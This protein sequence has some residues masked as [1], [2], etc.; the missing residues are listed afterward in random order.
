[1]GKRATMATTATMR[2][3][4]L[5]VVIAVTIPKLWCSRWSS[6]MVR[7]CM[8]LYIYTHTKTKD[9]YIW[10]HIDAVYCLHYW[11][12]GAASI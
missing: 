1:V 5:R 4:I 2:I 3:I 10:Q 9:A 6:A 12:S 8:L 7:C 11:Q